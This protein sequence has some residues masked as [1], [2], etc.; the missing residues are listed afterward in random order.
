[1]TRNFPKN[2]PTSIERNKK[3]NKI[4]GAF[5]SQILSRGHQISVHL[6]KQEEGL[7]TSVRNLRGCDNFLM[8][9]ANRWFYAN[10]QTY[11]SYYENRMNHRLKGSV[12]SLLNVFFLLLS[13]H[14]G[15]LRTTRRRLER[16]PRRDSGNIN[17]S[18]EDRYMF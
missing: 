14:P 6:M 11:F 7:L 3:Q 13:R 5:S 18:V 2:V 9:A 4:S 8:C 17:K 12:F 1:M 16:T 10:S 15:K